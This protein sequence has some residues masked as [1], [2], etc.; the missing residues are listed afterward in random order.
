MMKRCFI[1]LIGTLLSLSAFAQDLPAGAVAFIAIEGDH[2]IA[3]AIV[4]TRNIPANTQISFTDNKW[5]GTA[6]LS[7]EGTVIWTT[8]DTVLPPGTIVK[9]RDGGA[10]VGMTLVGPGTVSGR[11]FFFLGMGDQILAYTGPST[12]PSFIAGISTNIWR[13]TCD[14]ISFWEFRTCLPPPLKNGLTAICFVNVSTY[15]IDNGYF[16]VTPFNVT[17]PDILPIV[18]NINYWTLSND[19]DAGYGNWP[20]WSSNETQPFA[21][22]IEFAQEQMTITEG[23]AVGN[24]VLNINTPQFTP[25]TAVLNVLHFPGV[26]TSDYH[27]SP[28]VSDQMTISLEIPANASSVTIPVQALIDGFPELDENLTLVIGS[29][30]GGLAKGPKDA[31]AI[32]IKNADNA[33]LSYIEFAADTV[34]VTEGVGS[35]SVHMKIVPPVPVQYYVILDVQNGP[36]VSSD[37]L[38]T[39]SI[40]NQQIL[41]GPTLANAEGISFTVTPINDFHIEPDEFVRL[42]ISVI[43]PEGLLTGPRSTMTILI[44]DNDAVPAYIPPQIFIN[45]LNLH[46]TDFPDEFGENDAWIEIYNP[47]T[48]EVNLSGLHISNSLANPTKFT[49]PQLSSQLTIGPKQ[50]MILWADHQT[51]QGA[52]HLNFTLSQDGG[53]IGL[54]APDGEQLI[55][56]TYYPTQREGYSFGRIPDGEG[57]FK[58]LHIPTPLAANTDSIPTS[59]SLNELPDAGIRAIAFP[60]PAGGTKVEVRFLN[61]PVDLADFE[62]SISDLSG[63]TFPVLKEVGVN[64]Q[65]FLV[66]IGNL[67]N[68]YY[69]IRYNAENAIPLVIAR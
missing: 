40:A 36:G 12:N 63:R 39:P 52:R 13:A 62:W 31:I 61:S 25:Q 69:F 51:T 27:I 15:N 33:N 42:T 8:P 18:N 45:E 20:D 64:A 49:F 38:T 26:S 53:F 24:V 34:V 47:D 19:G 23:G 55:D 41:L 43:T 57:E 68:G 7:N 29:L 59:V 28:P 11:I 6:L 3:F 65:S 35:A 1:W 67:A 32:T 60:N 56:G 5:T 4:T 9:F 50:Y 14:T 54:Y 10:G 58:V 37:Y 48:S 46:N 17:G 22:I 44:R 16:A 2:P 21:G 30:S 66:D